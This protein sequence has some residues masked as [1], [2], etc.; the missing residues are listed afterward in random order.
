[1]SCKVCK[2]SGLCKEKTGLPIFLTRYAIA[3]AIGGEAK[4]FPR[5]GK[6]R[7]AA[8]HYYKKKGIYFRESHV[9]YNGE[10]KSN[11]K[12]DDKDYKEYYEK[13]YKRFDDAVKFEE[14]NISESNAPELGGKFKINSQ[15]DLKAITKGST[16]YTL[17]TLRT[18][19]LYL[20]DE[21]R[22]EWQAWTVTAD[23]F[24][25]PM[26]VYY[27][28]TDN[29]V[30]PDP[31]EKPCQA[32]NYARAAYITIRDAE[33]AGKI[34]ITFSDVRW[35]R[36]VWER[37]THAKTG[38][39]YRAKHMRMFDVGAWVQ[40]GAPV[41]E[42]SANISEL[43]KHVAD[44]AENINENAFHF[45]MSENE[46]SPFPRLAW[47]RNFYRV[48]DPSDPD[49]VL[50]SVSEYARLSDAEKKKISIVEQNR[51]IKAAPRVIAASEKI[52]KGT[53]LSDKGIIIALDDPVGITRELAGL[54]AHR[55]QAFAQQPRFATKIAGSANILEAKGFKNN[56]AKNYVLKVA[57]GIE[58]EKR[59]WIQVQSGGQ[60]AFDSL[61]RAEPSV[62]RNA[63]LR[64]LQGSDWDR[65]RTLTVPIPMGLL[66][67]RFE[68][69]F[70]RMWNKAVYKNVRQNQDETFTCSDP[71]YD[72][73]ARAK[74][75]KEEYPAAIAPYLKEIIAP[76][77]Q[78]HAQWLE[79]DELAD[80]F[81][82]NFSTIEPRQGVSYL[83]ILSLCIADAATREPCRK[84]VEKWMNGKH[85]SHKNLILRAHALNQDDFAKK[86]DT[87]VGDIEKLKIEARAKFPAMLNPSKTTEELKE[88]KQIIAANS[89]IHK[90]FQAYLVTFANAWNTVST[91]L[92]KVPKEIAR[93]SVNKLTAQLSDVVVKNHPNG[94]ITPYLNSVAAHNN[95]HQVNYSITGTGYQ[96]RELIKYTVLNSPLPGDTTPGTNTLVRE[97]AINHVIPPRLNLAASEVTARAFGT[98]DIDALQ[99]FKAE[100]ANH[101]EK[102]MVTRGDLK[103]AIQVFADKLH[104]SPEVLADLHE[105]NW[106]KNTNFDFFNFCRRVG[107]GQDFQRQVMDAEE[108]RRVAGDDE[109]VRAAK[110]DAARARNQAD[111]ARTQAVDAGKEATRAKESLDTAVKERDR[112]NA[113]L[114]QAQE[115]LRLAEANRDIATENFRSAQQNAQAATR[116]QIGATQAALE[117]ASRQGAG[118][119]GAVHAAEAGL[120]SAQQAVSTAT[121]NVRSLETAYGAAANR[122]KELRGNYAT[123]NTNADAKEQAALDAVKK[124]G[125]A[126]QKYSDEVGKI[127]NEDER[128]AAKEKALQERRENKFKKVPQRLRIEGGFCALNGLFVALSLNSVLKEIPT[129]EVW[130]NAG[131]ARARFAGFSLMAISAACEVTMNLLKLGHHARDASLIRRF[132][133]LGRRLVGGTLRLV[134]KW[135]AV[136]GSVITA[137]ADFW[138]AYEEY[139]RGNYALMIVYIASG[140][141]A[142]V[143]A[144]LLASATG[145]GFVAGCILLSAALA[146]ST[147]IS[148][149]KDDKLQDYL[150]KCAFGAE[151]TR[152]ANWT[153]EK[154]GIAY[155]Q[156]KM[157]V[158]A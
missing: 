19:F 47:S 15:V 141:T 60:F 152:A 130:G 34:W 31:E 155:Q 2:E 66:E 52:L 3:P 126:Q 27:V 24:L 119:W 156:A 145:I 23:A 84:V 110:N 122:A 91:A 132:T 1:M 61:N 93:E 148:I 114:T 48:R 115:R 43:G 86:L 107:E 16:H 49:R 17:R 140:V 149:F 134:A 13:H 51:A 29:N 8:H 28:F 68:I 90:A 26:P 4:F 113:A 106:K 105:L 147:A 151:K 78:A 133:V 125:E 99:K 117:T 92:S 39:A 63:I 54:M 21:K 144:L 7:N 65:D 58:Y 98:F 38:A 42:H 101:F 120:S 20:Y 150:G 73:E 37:Y 116:G 22:N 5:E 67:K 127:I 146:I 95:H 14:H 18:G 131:K 30:A 69:N 62:E 109:R 153:L 108:L 35:T 123:A 6:G 10:F 75:V 94:G 128:L 142:L 32:Q 143:G 88:D 83:N 97:S 124:Q 82:C 45:S 81:I 136:V 25:V 89:Q 79:S 9:D 74:F 59:R 72:E 112:L 85:A 87:H 111:Q 138:D 139:G 41:Q 50:M 158:P 70:E 55:E 53:K 100:Y 129:A 71:R 118:A 104:L 96:H 135:F 103:V 77:S 56:E 11:K 76:I 40:P 33:N 64:A 12:E 46:F 154:D 36:D 121:G 80:R 57:E 137:F 102:G 44:F 157:A